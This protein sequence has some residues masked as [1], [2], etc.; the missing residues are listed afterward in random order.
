MTITDLAER[1]KIQIPIYF[2]S[3]ALKGIEQNYTKTERIILALVNVVRRLQKHFQGHPIRVLTDRPIKRMLSNPDRT[4]RIAKWA[5]ELGEHDS[6]YHDENF[7]NG[8]TPTSVS[9]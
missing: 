5:I 4:Q 1:R 7:L 9:S 3:R 2:A 6:E 8:Q